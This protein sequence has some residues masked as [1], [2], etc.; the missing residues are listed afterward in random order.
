M[1]KEIVS[2][3]DKSIIN[4]INNEWINSSSAKVQTENCY[5]LE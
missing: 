5:N 4:N 3:I 1:E 2:S